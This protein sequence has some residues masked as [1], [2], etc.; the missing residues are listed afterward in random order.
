MGGEAPMAH[1]PVVADMGLRDVGLHGDSR[2]SVADA[3]TR[4]RSS[5]IRRFG[6]CEEDHFEE[7][8][9]PREG[10]ARG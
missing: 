1:Q 3:R 4:S 6:R 7:V 2:A 8:G 5:L 10:A 9:R